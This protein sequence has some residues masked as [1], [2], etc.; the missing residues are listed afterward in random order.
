[1]K[2]RYHLITDHEPTK[3]CWK[4]IK[5]S[6]FIITTD[7]ERMLVSNP[8][9]HTYSQYLY[10]IRITYDQ[11]PESLFWDVRLWSAGLLRIRATVSTE[12]PSMN[13]LFHC[14]QFE[15]WLK[16]NC[17]HLNWKFSINFTSTGS[18]GFKKINNS[19]LQE[20]KFSISQNISPNLKDLPIIITTF[21]IPINISRQQWST[22]KDE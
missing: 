9:S 4:V 16:L 11:Q 15:I 5:I 6:T 21:I 10:L 20:R 14:L 12:V 3:N 19:M 17:D 1:M 2:T 22:S 18:N 7:E 8:N 13:E